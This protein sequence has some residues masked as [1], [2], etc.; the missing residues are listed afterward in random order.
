MNPQTAAHFEEG[1]DTGT[2]PLPRPLKQKIKDALVAVSMANL[3]F[4]LV[5][6]D[7]L[8]DADRLF[9]LLPVT[10]STLL[11]LTTN[12]AGLALIIW[13]GIRA[14]RRFPNRWFQVPAHLLFILLLLFPV[15]FIRIKYFH[16]ADYEILKLFE[17]PVIM[18][19]AVAALALVVWQHRL[20][21]RTAA[22]LAAILSPL[23]LMVLGKIALVCVG[24]ATIK[25]CREPSTWLPLN[26]VPHGQPRVVWIIFDCT[27]YRLAYEQRPA[28]V[29]LP[30]FDRLRSE[31]LFAD[32][33][34]SPGSCTI[35]S[36][37]A[38]IY[39]QVVSAAD[40]SDTCDLT[41]TFADTGATTGCTGL[42]S[43]FTKARQLGFNNA[44]VGWF[45]PYGRLVGRDLNFCEWYPYPPFEPG[46]ADT[47]VANVRQQFLSLGETF[48]LRHLF[49]NVHRDSL[50]VSLSVVTNASYGLTL[51]HLPAPHKP[52]V[53]LADKDQLTFWPRLSKVAGYFNN[54]VLADREFGKLRRA[55]ETSGE[56]DNTWIILSSDHA[57]SESNL[58]DHK[59][60]PRVPFI[61][62][63]PGAN[64]PIAYANPFNTV[65]TD[66]LILAIL[67]KQVTNHQDVANWLDAHRPAQVAMP[68]VGPE[69]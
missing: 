42:P 52:G 59:L 68:V 66:A 48:W 8:S 6:F 47:Y 54:L 38:L 21:A 62:H 15:D 2:V 22:I 9:D 11:A 45:I 51:L 36:M 3:C 17:Q 34:Y 26:P 56:W 4:L 19:C 13:L 31:S 37:P 28:N 5:S 24:L 53:Y 46:R 33:A 65:L 43:I 63:A 58:Y 10:T 40:T 44:V 50:Q 61:V 41:V 64:D 35:L 12:I 7:L 55:M 49:A 27:D 18:A 25:E 67:Q 16:V 39:G 23:A 60:D 20:A 57:W 30:E 69:P 29:Q 1:H 32:H 14:V